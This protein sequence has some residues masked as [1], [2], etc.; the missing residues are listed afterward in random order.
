LDSRFAWFVGRRAVN[1]VVTIIF[2]IALI[3]T[4]V[5]LVAPTPEDLAR[6]Y[7]GGTAHITQAILQQVAKRYGFTQP[8][9]IQFLT[10]VWN[11][12]HGNLGTD[13]IYNIPEIIVIERY[14][15][16]TIDMVVLGTILGV[17]L[18]I[19]TGTIA[20]SNRNTATDYGIKALY[21]G[22]WAAPPFLAA[23]VFQIVMAYYLH[24]L[25][26]GGVA[27]PVLTV[28]PAV[29]GLPLIDS[30]LAH[31]WT[32]LYSYLQHLILPALTIALIS[33]GAITRITRATMVDSLD[34]DYVRLAYMKGLTKRKVVYGTAFRNALIPIIT[35]LAITFAF[36]IGGAVIV[37][38]IFNYHGIGYFAVNA[39]YALDYPAVLGITIFV[40]LAVIIANFIAD[41][42]YGVM[43]PRV[44]L[45]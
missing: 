24:L 30:L 39:A 8:V 43:D 13:S 16:I 37:E 3:F 32:F 22:T 26:T 15:P 7:I 23:I 44:R 20:A 4:I 12:F 9:Y 2:M 29:T 33:F 19:F 35:L 41:I 36:S 40:G 21:L 28:P 34:K 42:L 45:T 14:F 27:N 5:H 31:D 18:G 17:V 1:A 6:L 11:F 38:D 10:Y 25:P